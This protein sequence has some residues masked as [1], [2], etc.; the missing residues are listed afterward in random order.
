[1]QSAVLE[2][3]YVVEPW[4][5][6]I[7]LAEELPFGSWMLVSGLMTQ[8]HAMLAGYESRATHDIDLLIDVMVSASKV[9]SVVEGLKSLGNASGFGRMLH[10]L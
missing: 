6:V 8:A 7:E 2:M 4:G 9:S 3:N 1:M 5:S 10:T